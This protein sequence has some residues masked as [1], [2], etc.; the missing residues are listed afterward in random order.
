[1]FV[2]PSSHDPA[3]Q[4][5]PWMLYSLIFLNVILWLITS[6]S[7]Y[8][9]L[10]DNGFRPNYPKLSTAIMSG[11]SHAS[12]MHLA[13]NMIF[14]WTFGKALEGR[15]GSFNLLMVYFLA[16]AFAIIAH[17][18]THPRDSTLLVGASGAVSGIMGLYGFLF[19]KRP[20]TLHF[21]LFFL[22]LGKMQVS[23]LSAVCSWFAVDLFM[24]LTEDR[25]VA[26]GTATW[27][28]LGGALLG[29]ILGML[30]DGLKQSKSD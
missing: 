10:D 29:F 1:M 21:F 27:A 24:A 12:F 13:G 20:I 2:L 30:Y 19:S 11:F 7:G 26:G 3:D 22:R 14:L 16:H 8:Q 6:A 15:I 9:L 18:V 28:H 4:R 17:S 5:I 23:A 25:S